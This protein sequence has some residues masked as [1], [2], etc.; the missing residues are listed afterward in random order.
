MSGCSWEN[1]GSG[2]PGT[3]A[4]KLCFVCNVLYVLVSQRVSQ[5]GGLQSWIFFKAKPFSVLELPEGAS[6]PVLFEHPPMGSFA[7]EPW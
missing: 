7:E 5:Q 2:H 3:P 1:H 4:W 6:S